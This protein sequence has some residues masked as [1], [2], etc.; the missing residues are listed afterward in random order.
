MEDYFVRMGRRG[1]R[2]TARHRWEGLRLRCG[3]RV[4]YPWARAGVLLMLILPLAGCVELLIGV[5]SL[6]ASGVGIYQRVE[7]RDV[8]KDQNAEIKALRQSVEQHQGEV[9]RLNER[10]LDLQEEH[11]KKE[12]SKEKN[13]GDE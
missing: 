13:H 3:T 6:L 8:Q 11:H 12:V 10:L 5:G 9:K 7:D 1:G 2:H 4:W